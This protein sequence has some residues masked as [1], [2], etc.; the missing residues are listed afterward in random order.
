MNYCLNETEIIMWELGI[1]LF[2]LFIGLLLK[3]YQLT[4]KK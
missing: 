2:L 3:I 1:G 4:K